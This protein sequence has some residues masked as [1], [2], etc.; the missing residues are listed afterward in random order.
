MSFSFVCNG[1]ADGLNPVMWSPSWFWWCYKDVV[2]LSVFWVVLVH[3][4]GSWSFPGWISSSLSWFQVVFFVALRRINVLCFFCVWR[5]F[6]CGFLACPRCGRAVAFTSSSSR[7]SCRRS[8]GCSLISA[9]CRLRVWSPLLNWSRL[10]PGMQDFAIACS[11]AGYLASSTG[12]SSASDCSYSVSSRSSFILFSFIFYLRHVTS[13]ISVIRATSFWIFSCTNFI[14]SSV[15]CSA[16]VFGCCGARFQ[17][18]VTYDARTGVPSVHHLY[19][20]ERAW[21]P[22]DCTFIYCVHT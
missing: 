5:S 16:L 2:Y 21:R 13:L 7:P 9:T 8:V 11:S 3:S 4:M 14:S 22:G 17:C 20:T 10:L 18:V 1:V 15:R 6:V 12:C 19:A